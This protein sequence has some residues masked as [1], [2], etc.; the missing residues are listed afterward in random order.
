MP[1]REAVHVFDCV[2]FNASLRGIDVGAD[3]AFLVMDLVRLGAG[4]LAARLIEAYR[5]AGGDPGNDA[6][7]SF[8][9]S[10]RAWVRAKVAC[11]RVHE[12]EPGDPERARQE[13]EAREFLRLGHRFAWGARRPLVLVVCGVAGTGK[14]RLAR[15][16]A[17]L[18]GWT[19]VSSDV[20]R[21]RLAGLVPTERGGRELY[22]PAFT[23]RTYR[24]L[25][26]TAADELTQ[27]GGV[28]VDATFHRRSERAAF[29]DGLGDQAA[30]LLIVKCRASTEVLLTRVRERDL[31]PER[32]SDA[33]ATII[34]RQLA[35]LEPL[36]EVPAETRL[37]LLTEA[38]PDELAVAV[39][40]FVDESMRRD[41]VGPARV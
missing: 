22:S 20:T 28:I 15:E 11:L 18:S 14:T 40:G 16:L 35:E 24:E 2:E 30:P 21:K 12:L 19:H 39:E 17:E 3:I 27:E 26:R 13:A 1:A 37:D 5:E 8:F 38:D 31:D 29:R 36:S 4:P 34:R 10:Y 25:G 32:T 41:A 7:V 33:D 9:A 23:S 6:L